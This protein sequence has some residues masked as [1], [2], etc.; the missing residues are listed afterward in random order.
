MHLNYLKFFCFIDQFDKNLIKNLT[1]NVIIIYRN[2]SSKDHQKTIISIKK[3]CK[4]KG[5]KFYISN[6]F[7]L[8]I[9]LDLDGVYIPAFNKNLS[10][11]V[12]NYKKKF[13][14]IGSAHS[15]KE[16]RN[17]EIQG[18]K[19]IFI[20]PVFPNKKTKTN[21]GIYRFSSIKKLTNKN[22]VCLGGVK[23]ENL[24]ILKHLNI[25]GIASISLF[26]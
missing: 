22:V 17:K 5:L 23:K 14:V 20:S 10:L 15:L 18:V 4:K 24:K 25:Y 16:I 12:Y 2:Y 11:N 26:R 8:A 7:K 3:Y 6:N 1:K 13:C 19:T 9:K 21:L